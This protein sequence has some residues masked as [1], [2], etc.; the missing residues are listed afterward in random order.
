MLMALGHDTSRTFKRVSKLQLKFSQMLLSGPVVDD[1][2][3]AT[4][5]INVKL[6]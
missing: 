4:Q 5:Q 3:P 6:A 1:D 2:S